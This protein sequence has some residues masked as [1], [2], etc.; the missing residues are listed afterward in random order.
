MSDPSIAVI[1][2]VYKQMRYLPRCLASVA[3]QLR[4]YESVVV[5]YS[6]EES[7]EIEHFQKECPW[8][9]MAK[10]VCSPPKTVWG[11]AQARNEGIRHLSAILE[12]TQN[13]CDWLKFLDA[14]DVLAPFA[15]E[16]FR[17]CEIPDSV[18]VVSGAM[19][20]VV[21]GKITGLCQTN[22]G[23]IGIHN[24]ALVSGCFVRR[25]AFFRVGGFD[26]RIHFEEDW[27]FWLRI[28]KEFPGR[29]F[30]GM[31]W[32]VCYYWISEAERAAKVRDH[33]IEY[34]GA[35]IDVREYFKRHYGITPQ[36]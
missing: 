6:H 12:A 32:P 14:D 35:R 26:E 34:E 27:D 16:A 31:P 5:A 13:A 15:L 4:F 17:E 11:P 19:V 28:Q 1:I 20:K 21:D 24:P 3:T 33:T 30:G 25:T 8:A 29:P 36:P 9:M 22:W 18:Q 7:A 2:P 23:M 10:Y